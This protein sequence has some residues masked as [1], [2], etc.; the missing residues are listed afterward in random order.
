[1]DE[2]LSKRSCSSAVAFVLSGGDDVVVEDRC[3]RERVDI[4][5][6]PNS[7]VGSSF[8]VLPH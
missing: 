6:H 1:M 2:R 7:R 5:P 4:L 8:P 3:W